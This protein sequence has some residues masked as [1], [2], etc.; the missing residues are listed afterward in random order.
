MRRGGE[1]VAWFNCSAGVAGDMMLGALVDAGADPAE[2]A[3][4]VAGLGIDGCAL[5]FERV[6]RAGVRAT[7]ANVVVHE[8]SDDHHHDHHPH[9][10]DHDHHHDHGHHDHGH[11]HH[12]HR[13]AGE[14]LELIRRADL[15]ERVRERALRVYAELAEVEGEIHGIPADEVELHEVGAADAII[16]V[17]GT[18]AALE[19]L[20][21]DR[22]VCGP[23][24]V[25][26]GSVNT[27]HGLLPNPAPA[28]VRLLARHRAPARGVDTTMEL[29]TPTGVALVTVLADSFGPLPEMAVASV[30]FG[31]GTADP[32]GRPN[33]VNV[34]VGRSTPG[35]RDATGRPGTG[36]RAHLVEANVDDATPE[37]LAHTVRRLLHAGAHD[38]WITPI[39]MKK[40][41]PAHTVSALCDD[42]TLTEVTQTLV[43]ESG[44]LGVRATLVERWPQA[45]H[46]AT[47]EVD[48][49]AIRVKQTPGVERV[50]V[51]HDDAVAAADALGIPLRLVMER[52]VAAAGDLDP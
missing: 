11:D 52:A 3:H 16:D 33:V 35:R 7:W 46:E 19:S 6:Q 8:S 13:P 18:C 1:T 51:E 47:V 10:D 28:V 12:P 30:G 14:V 31:A 48:G 24:S 45:R 23:I 9:D 2:V 43:D 29:A 20:G 34:V 4:A 44:T 15:P 50:K 39:V 21:V 17:V 22:L 25:G 41:R 42:A 26:S 40:G 49:H 37:V 5:T 36:R 27:A 38:A 32:T